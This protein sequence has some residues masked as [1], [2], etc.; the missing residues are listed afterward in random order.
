MWFRMLIGGWYVSSNLTCELG[1]ATSLECAGETSDV[2][3]RVA[4]PLRLVLHRGHHDSRSQT[5]LI[6]EELVG[7]YDIDG[8]GLRRRF[9]EVRVVG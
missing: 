2:Q 4:V 8:V 7:M 5:E 3:R 6:E 1:S 9:G